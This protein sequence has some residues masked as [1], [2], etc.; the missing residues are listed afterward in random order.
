MDWYN[1]LSIILGALGGAG[2]SLYTAKSNK[3]TIDI[4]NFQRL[5][6]EE[7]EER[8]LLKEEYKEYKE[9]VERKVE[10]VKADVEKMQKD[11]KKMITS[12]FQAYKCKLPEKIQDCPVVKFFLNQG[13][14]KINGMNMFN[15]IENGVG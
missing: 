1:I 6:E 9:T 12:I 7:R 5:I 14:D 2:V 8:R 3:D 13:G 11:N 15:D 10:K 4:S